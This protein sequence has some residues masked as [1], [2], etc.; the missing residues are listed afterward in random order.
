MLPRRVRSAERARFLT[1]V[2]TT[3][4]EGG[5]GYWSTVSEY[6]WYDPSLDQGTALHNAGEP[7]AYVTVH[8][9]DDSELDPGV[10]QTIGVEEIA[11]ALRKI[12][13]GE[14]QHLHPDI[15]NI[16]RVNNLTNGE[17][18]GKVEDIDA[19]LADVIVQVAV[20]GEVRYG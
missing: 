4:V 14:V 13:N 18:D 11:E 10:V 7:N 17:H 3:A 5:I 15:A 6:H 9:H 19:S 1:D 16:I 12:G 20:L 2:L 8:E